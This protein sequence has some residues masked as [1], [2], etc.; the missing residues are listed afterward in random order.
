[1]RKEQLIQSILDLMVSKGYFKKDDSIYNIYKGL[2]KT[3]TI[4]Q[5]KELQADVERDEYIIF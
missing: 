1:M 2:M 5:L 4:G 3:D